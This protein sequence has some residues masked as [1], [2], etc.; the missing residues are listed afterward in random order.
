MV[1]GSFCSFPEAKTALD[2]GTG[3]GV[4]ALMVAQTH[5]N[6][7]IDAIDI[8]NGNCKDAKFNVVNSPFEKRI[9]VIHEDI[10]SFFPLK[11]YDF[12]FSNPP[13]HIEAVKNIDAR[14]TRAK[15]FHKNEIDSFVQ[16]LS[17][18][19]SKNGKIAM[20]FSHDGLF[21][22]KKCFTR[23]KLFV[24]EIIFVYGNPKLKKRA[25]VTCSKSISLITKKDFIIR[26]YAGNY[27][28]E[29]IEKTKE[30]HGTILG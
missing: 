12:I 22:L 6:L 3:T 2:V 25:I 30:F 16:K 11:K 15:H 8:D 7:I 9:N 13:F 1:F 28:Q 27:T 10:F 23:H 20:I 17:K 18:L 29:Y 26:D 24:N 19:L 4:L 14:I 21:E 5:P